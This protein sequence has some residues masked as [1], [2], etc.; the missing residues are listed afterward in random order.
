M[1]NKSL[2]EAGAASLISALA[3]SPCRENF[4]RL[5]ELET[6]LFSDEL[7]IEALEK[8]LRASRS[9]KILDFS[10]KSFKK[11]N[12]VSFLTIISEG[13]LLVS[14][15]QPPIL[16]DD[17]YTQSEIHEL[18]V[19]IISSSDNLKSVNCYNKNMTKE[20]VCE[21]LKALIGSESINTLECL[22][23]L[24][25]DVYSSNEVLPVITEVYNK[26]KQMKKSNFAGMQL[27]ASQTLDLLNFMINL[28]GFAERLEELYMGDFSHKCTDLTGEGACD[29]VD[30]ILKKAINLRS[31]MLPGIGTY[32]DMFFE[33]GGCRVLTHSDKSREFLTYLSHSEKLI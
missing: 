3:D 4:T 30:T 12:I 9:F 26:A 19:K 23:L 33:D 11:E 25:A 13:G 1:L 16:D 32:K 28:Q 27:D 5:P 20:Q 24:D 31:L 15:E 8:M 22:P 2:D 7:V 18:L 14:L 10:K 29:L 21:V 17:L 6:H